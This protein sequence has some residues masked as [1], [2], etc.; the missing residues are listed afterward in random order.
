MTNWLEIARRELPAGDKKRLSSV[1]AVGEVPAFE[2]LESFRWPQHTIDVEEI[3]FNDSDEVLASGAEDKTT[4]GTTPTAKIAETPLPTI[5][6]VLNNSSVGQSLPDEHAEGVGANVSSP[7]TKPPKIQKG[8]GE[9]LPKLTKA[10]ASDERD[11]A[12]ENSA[13]DARHWR[14]KS[15]TALS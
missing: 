13:A 14:R 15:R 10:L 4:A 9:E 11:K 6:A 7:Q 2:K 5:M 8:P 3:L 12:P 1:S